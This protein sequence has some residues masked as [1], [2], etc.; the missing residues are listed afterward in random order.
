VGRETVGKHRRSMVQD[1]DG[2]RYYTIKEAAVLLRRHRL[3][4][5]RWTVENKIRFHQPSV[6]SKIL[7]PQNE[8]NRKLRG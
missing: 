5:W 1:I 6:G 8:I 7:I 2:E 3:T 4:V